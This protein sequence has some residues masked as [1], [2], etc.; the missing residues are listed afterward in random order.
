MPQPKLNHEESQKLL[1]LAGE[2]R[3]FPPDHFQPDNIL[4]WAKF[5]NIAPKQLAPHTT[6]LSKT[7]DRAYRILQNEGAI[8]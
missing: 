5:F 4:A 6:E 8:E 3:N 2:M 1:Q 7:L